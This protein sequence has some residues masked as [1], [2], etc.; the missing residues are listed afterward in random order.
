MHAKA[1]LVTALRTNV[2]R[3][4][5]SSAL[6]LLVDLNIQSSNQDYVL[7]NNVLFKEC[8]RQGYNQ[9]KL[10][11]NSCSYTFWGSSSS[12]SAWSNS[13]RGLAVTGDEPSSILM[14]RKG[15]G[16]LPQ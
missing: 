8:N 10:V 1:L 7:W 15:G 16:R 12:T 13:S 3:R 11:C 4:T 6:I 9:H 2:A 5:R 14:L